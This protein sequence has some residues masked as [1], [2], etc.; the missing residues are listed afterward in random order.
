[1]R[2]VVG[3]CKLVGCKPPILTERGLEPRPSQHRFEKV[4]LGSLLIE[5][6]NSMNVWSDRRGWVS[7][8]RAQTVNRRRSG[9]DIS[10]ARVKGKLGQVECFRTGLR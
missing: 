9:E 7:V 4:E 6:Y 5:P 1:M 8:P 3:C 2:V 10:C